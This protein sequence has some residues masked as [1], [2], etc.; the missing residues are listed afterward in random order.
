MSEGSGTNETPRRCVE[1]LAARQ[2]ELRRALDGRSLRVLVDCTDGTTLQVLLT[3][4]GFVGLVPADQSFEPQVE[5]RGPAEQVRAFLRERT[6]L[7]DAVLARLV[8]LRMPEDE[9]AGYRNLRRLVADVI[10]TLD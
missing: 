3:R 4:G 2:E 1:A 8:T 10:D 7:A 9:V 6:S 5:I